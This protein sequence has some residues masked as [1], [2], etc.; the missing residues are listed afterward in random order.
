MYFI[1]MLRSRYIDFLVMKFWG[2]KVIKDE[3][4]ARQNNALKQTVGVGTTRAM[5]T[6]CAN[7]RLLLNADVLLL[8]AAF[9][10]VRI[11]GMERKEMK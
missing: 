6:G 1:C 11:K 3:N 2:L 8:E 9:E 4:I 10:A 5:R 7:A